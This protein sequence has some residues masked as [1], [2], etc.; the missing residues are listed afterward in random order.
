MMPTGIAADVEVLT[1][2][3]ALSA[4]NPFVYI[5]SDGQVANASAAVG[6]N[7]AW[8]FVTQSYTSGATDVKVY[9]EGRVSGFTGLSI[10]ARYY[11][12]DATAG[13]VTATP[14]SGT[15]KIHQ[16][17]GRAA[18]ATTISFETGDSDH[19]VLA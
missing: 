19:I 4:S 2:S 6:G 13:A 10:G 5:K 16:Y 11:L 8:G 18:T 12:S 1:A 3:E 17:I 14:V 9:F 15:G 7:A